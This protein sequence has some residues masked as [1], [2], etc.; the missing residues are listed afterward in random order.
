MADTNHLFDDR[1]RIETPLVRKSGKLVPTTWEEALSEVARHF[2]QAEYSA[3]A[4]SRL[5]VET[6]HALKQVFPLHNGIVEVNSVISSESEV[7]EG[8]LSELDKADCFIV[9]GTDLSENQQVAGF[10]VKRAVQSGAELVVIDSKPNSFDA[11]S[12][13]TLK[14]HE[15][16]PVLEGL[17]AALLKLGLNKT[18]ST[19]KPWDI[20]GTLNAKT[21]V[22]VEAITAAAQIIGSASHIAIVYGEGALESSEFAGTLIEFA[23]ITG[24]LDGNH[25]GVVG[26]KG[27]ANAVAA[28]LL[29][30]KTTITSKSACYL[31]LGDAEIS[32]ELAK[33]LQSASYLVVQASYASAIT[34]RADVVL[35]AAIWA[36]ETGH[37]IN[38]EGTV[39]ETAIA[40]T[41]APGIKSNTEIL[42]ALAEKI[43]VQLSTDWQTPLHAVKSPVALHKQYK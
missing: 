34:D 19:I 24:A 39:Q 26:V 12:A 1:K 10:M 29:G 30:M 3:I 16:G 38:L 31:A 18:P 8:N 4:S 20:L 9:I 7:F 43:G 17:G 23:R 15:I 37:F 5:S 32:D 14:A 40:L 41:A 6:L 35:P 42:T 33:S 22:E 21:G 13:Y 25:S 36:E 28:S 11:F 2:K 27:T